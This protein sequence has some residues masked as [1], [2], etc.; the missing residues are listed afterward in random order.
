MDVMLNKWGNS[1]GLRLPREL[2]DA[3]KF[4]P[5]SR[6]SISAQ[7]S[8]I[9]IEPSMTVESLFEA[10]YGKPM[11]SIRREEIGVYEETDW[12]AD[13]GEEVID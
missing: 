4:R 5:G 8:K 1:L 12:G 2:V 9:T 3:F 10:H 11:E 6:V 13:V 7:G